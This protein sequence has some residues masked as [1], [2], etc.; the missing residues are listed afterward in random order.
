MSQLGCRDCAVKVVAECRN[1]ISKIWCGKP[2][3]LVRCT[4]WAGESCV[5][6]A[7]ITSAVF[8]CVLRGCSSCCCGTATGALVMGWTKA[9]ARVLTMA[10]GG[11][12]HVNTSGTQLGAV[13]S[14][15]GSDVE[16]ACL[17]KAI[18]LLDV[19]HSHRTVRVSEREAARTG[20]LKD[21]YGQ[22]DG[23]TNGRLCVYDNVCA[24]CPRTKGRQ[25]A[26]TSRHAATTPR[27]C[28]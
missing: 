18:V 8:H 3:P 20:R 11:N 22:G 4:G 12:G 5:H 24:C 25:D 15:S 27:F 1:R 14:T 2:W 6:R 26:D 21:N 13:L 17:R 19:I 28:V 23:R 9:C 16:G 10:R 7:C